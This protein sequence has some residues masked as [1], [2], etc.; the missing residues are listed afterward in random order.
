MRD[1]L[2]LET[3]MQYYYFAHF[4][5]RMQCIWRREVMFDS[6]HYLRVFKPKCSL[7]IYFCPTQNSQ[8]FKLWFGISMVC[9]PHRE[10]SMYMY[11]CCTCRVATICGYDCPWRSDDVVQIMLR[12]VVNPS[13]GLSPQRLGHNPMFNCTPTLTNILQQQFLTPPTPSDE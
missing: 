6:W 8:V 11:I 12:V 10:Y 4:R 1:G 7:R 9:H 13:A 5:S 3:L 2:L